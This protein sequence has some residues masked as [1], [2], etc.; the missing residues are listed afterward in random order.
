MTDLHVDHLPTPLKIVATRRRDGWTG[1]LLAAALLLLQ[2]CVWAL[3]VEIP[4]TAETGLYVNVWAEQY[5]G[6]NKPRI[7]PAPHLEPSTNYLLIVDLATIPYF[8]GFDRESGGI[9]LPL[10]RLLAPEAVHRYDFVISQLV[11]EDETYHPESE[12]YFFAVH[13][14][15]A[16][17]T[18]LWRIRRSLE[19]FLAADKKRVNRS[20]LSL[21]RSSDSGSRYGGPAWLLKRHLFLLR[22]RERTGAAPLG[23]AFRDFDGSILDGVSLRFCVEAPDRADRCRGLPRQSEY[24]AAQL[25]SDPPPLPDDMDFPAAAAMAGP[26]GR[27]MRVEPT[28]NSWVSRQ[29]DAAHK[30]VSTIELDTGPVQSLYKLHVELSLYQYFELLGLPSDLIGFA[31]ADRSFR[32]LVRER[33]QRGDTRLR[34]VVRAEEIGGAFEITS[35]RV[36]NLDVDLT[37]LDPDASQPNIQTDE[38]TLAQLSELTAAASMNVVV[39]P[40]APGCGAIALSI[41]DASGVRPLDQLVHTVEVRQSSQPTEDCPRGGVSSLSAGLSNILGQIGSPPVDAALHVFEL[42]P[43]SRPTAAAFLIRA[44]SEHHAWELARPLTEYLRDP[45]NLERR[46]LEARDRTSNGVEHAYDRAAQELAGAIFSG[47]DPAQQRE[48]DM[49]REVLRALVARSQEPPTLFA[50]LVDARGDVLFLPLGLLSAPGE[51]AV[52]DAPINVVLPLQQEDYA[53]SGCLRRWSVAVSDTLEGA[54]AVQVPEDIKRTDLWL[55]ESFEDLRGYFVDDTPVSGEG[56][57]VV[58]HHSGGRLRYQLNDFPLQAHQIRR[59]YG[60]ATAAV[61]AMCGVGSTSRVDNFLIR[62]L[63]G[64]G[65]DAAVLSPFSLDANYGKMFGI[66]FARIVRDARSALT[67]RE[68]HQKAVEATAQEMASH[69]NPS[70]RGSVG[71]MGLE[72]V[73]VGNPELRLCGR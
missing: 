41:A 50:R 54:E 36:Q 6:S 49:A 21:L 59:I 19:E 31:R 23:I 1:V 9:S 24:M 39:K 35:G 66:E 47:A 17:A 27:P 18:G 30:P 52:L 40:R 61:L 45:E 72:L 20:A 58:A 22:V 12:P 7:D 38:V 29:A 4:E 70:V 69:P 26:G 46:I 48:A 10:N 57:V 67:L 53:E 68:L 56:L 44:S 42:F 65:L 28:W 5:Q 51:H 14:D 11:V 16:K 33:L 73:L 34:L 55:G 3:T 62:R 25:S 2:P 43:W 8:D 60:E 37:R 13:G 64:F 71:D 15:R 32:D 63:N